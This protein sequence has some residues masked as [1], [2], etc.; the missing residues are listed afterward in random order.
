M[1]QEKSSSI[2]RF[3]S[4]E[5]K[6][7]WSNVYKRT[8]FLISGIRFTYKFV[9]PDIKTSKNICYFSMH[10]GFNNQFIKVMRTW[11]IFQKIKK[12]YILA[13]KSQAIMNR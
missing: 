13:S 11:P 2:R 4:Y 9:I 7:N 1:V 10:F 6:L 8:T 3:L 5:V 12:I